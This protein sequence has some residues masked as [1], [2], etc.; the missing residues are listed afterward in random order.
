[1]TYTEF[2]I[3]A[4]SHNN[5]QTTAQLVETFYEQ[6]PER[7]EA[8]RN[9]Y[10]AQNKPKTEKELKSQIHAEFGVYLIQLNKE[11]KVITTRSKGQ[12]NTHNIS[13]NAITTTT[14][15]LPQPDLTPDKND[16]AP[17]CFGTVYLMKSQT[18]KNTYKIGIT[19]DLDRRTKELRKDHRYGAFVLNP[20]ASMDC[21]DYTLVERVL[22]K[23]FE[24]F[25]LS[26]G[27]D[28]NEVAVDTELFIDIDTI[29]EEFNLFCEFITKNPRFK[30]TI[31]TLLP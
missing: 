8:R 5:T 21:K 20:I 17:E 3:A 29:E 30:N 23:F 28:N 14:T 15:E 25:R 9:Q 11:G 31:A 27:N 4:L 26:K 12:T 10:I 7:I 18:F 13:P 16:P 2:I 1:M 24:D 22:H 19:S 6:H